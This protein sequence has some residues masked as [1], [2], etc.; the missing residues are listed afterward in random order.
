MSQTRAVDD[1]YDARELKFQ[2][3]FE[4]AETLMISEV[5]FLL[6]HRKEQNENNPVHELELSNN[7]I[8][9]YRYISRLSEFNN[10]ETIES[11]RNLLV[12]RHLHNFELA[13]IANLLPDNVTEA[14]SLIP[15]L[16]KLRF[17]DEELQ[18]ILDE[19]HS[20]RSFQS[21]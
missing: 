19:V 8:K 14:R 15:S 21:S 4:T 12:Q 20:K 5:K 18:Q 3:E 10:R 1:D 6:D 11:V 2:K 13:S 9:T 16:D 17:P 7:F